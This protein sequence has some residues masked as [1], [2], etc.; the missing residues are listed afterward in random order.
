MNVLKCV[1]L[2]YN[3]TYLSMHISYFSD[4]NN[5]YWNIIYL[6]RIWDSSLPSSSCMGLCNFSHNHQTYH[7]FKLI[8][9]YIQSFNVF[10]S[11]NFYV[12]IDVLRTENTLVLRFT[13]CAPPN[14]EVSRSSGKYQTQIV[15]LVSKGGDG[16]FIENTP[17][18]CPWNR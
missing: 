6:Y 12:C 5:L 14:P 3:Y 17:P 9:I 13:M 16:T 15:S 10:K 11:T 7:P 2:E 1:Q 4:H 8:N 18:P